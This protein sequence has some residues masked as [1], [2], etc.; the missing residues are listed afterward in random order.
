[1][2]AVGVTWGRI[3]AL[4]CNWLMVNVFHRRLCLIL[5]VISV[6]DPHY[7]GHRQPLNHLCDANAAGGLKKE[8]RV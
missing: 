5:T 4:H 8:M 3:S 6:N 1:M 2:A 7:Q